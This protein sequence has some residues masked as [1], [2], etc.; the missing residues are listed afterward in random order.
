VFEQIYGCGKGDKELYVE[1][2]KNDN[3]KQKIMIENYE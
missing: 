1:R 2:R 3:K